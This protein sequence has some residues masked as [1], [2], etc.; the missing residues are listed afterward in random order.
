[1][2]K[3]NIKIRNPTDYEFEKSFW[4]RI[5]IY[6]PAIVSLLSFRCESAFAKLRQSQ[7]LRS[8]FSFLFSLRILSKCIPQNFDRM[9]CLAVSTIFY[10]VTATCTRGRDDYI[11][12]LTANSGE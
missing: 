2:K 11:F 3:L 4:K 12:R 10:L 8:S 9:Q 6:V 7:A 1:M 5:I